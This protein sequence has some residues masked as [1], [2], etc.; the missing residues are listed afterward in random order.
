M[1]KKILTE[2]KKS[3][4][5]ILIIFVVK[6]IIELIFKE[7]DLTE[8]FLINLKIIF[9]FKT[10]NWITD[11]KVSTILID[12]L[13]T[14]IVLF[15]LANNKIGLLHLYLNFL[16]KIKK[17]LIKNNKYAEVF[18]N[19]TVKN[20]IIVYSIKT[21]FGNI[22]INP[23]INSL[24]CPITLLLNQLFLVFKSEKSEET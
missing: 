18:L 4:L 14:I 21:E 24:I 9:A 7:I 6:I 11:I 16:E 17:K 20:L 8:I 22:K 23:T 12:I 19:E 10:V 1:K 5:I 2:V 15:F 13:M 3:L